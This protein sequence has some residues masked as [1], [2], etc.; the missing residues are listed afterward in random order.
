MSFV[1]LHVHSQ[2]SLLDG[3]SK[4]DKL[5]TRAQEMGM[6]AV[7]LTDHG[8]MFGT[9]D[10]FTAARKTG[11][12]P[13]IGLEAYMAARRMYDRDAK[14]DKRSSH[15]LLLAKNQIGYQNLLK[16]ASASQI[17]GFYYNPRIDHEFLAEHAEGL[18][19]SSGCM[20]AE[21]PRAIIDNNMDEVHKKLDWYYQVFGPENY[22]LELQSH[23]IQE[24]SK[25]NKTLLEVGKKYGSNFIATNDVHYVDQGDAY[26]Q[27]ILLAIQTG[28]LL[29]ETNRFRMSDDSYYLR[30]PQ[31]MMSLFA[32]IPGAIKNTVEIAERCNV[33]LTI[34]GYHLP[35]FEVPAGFTTQEY[36]LKVCDDGLKK[37]Y[38][39]HSEDKEVR[40]RL[41]Y[42]LGIIHE[43]G[44]DAYFL[45]VWDLCRHAREKGIWYNARGS[46]AGSM[47]AYV[48][49]ITLVEPLE[50]KLIFERFLN[51][52]RI[53]MPDI[54]L[55]FQ[56]DRRVEM[57]EYCA[58][59][60]GHDK[61][62]QI[63]TFGTLGARAAIRD[64]GRV[65]DIP[66]NEVDRV[67][68]SIPNIPSTSVSIK[69]ALEQSQEL[70][71]IYEEAD[72][73]AQLIDN[74]S[75]ME[76]SVRNA[77]THAA[78]VVITDEPVVNYLPLHRP[79]SGSEDSP[80]KTVTQYEMSVLDDLGLLK[81]DF[82]GLSTLTVMQKACD[83][84]EKRHGIKYDLSNIPLDD[85]E[86]Y[87]LLGKGNT[88][89]VFQLEGTGMTRHL[90]NM[91][92]HNLKNIIAMVALFRPG[93]MQFIPDYI[94]RMHGQD[95]PKYLH[96]KLE[97]I[98]SETYGIPIY[99]EQI[100]TAAMELAG[101]SASDADD[102]R[103]AISKKKIDKI[104]KHRER[105]IAGSVKNNVPK[106]TATE[107]FTEWE[108]FARYGFNKSHA[109]DYGVIAVQTAFLK[110]HYT[111]EY[112]TALLSVWKNV[113]DK[114][115]LYI[116]ECKS[117]G[118]EVLPPDIN[119]C[120]F[121]FTIED[122]EGKPPA[123][124]FG[125]GA[126][127]NVGQN[128]V[129]VIQDAANDGPFKD[130]N[131]FVR[132]VDL[133][134]VGKRPL[135]CLI[136]VGALDPLGKRTTLLD[137]LERICAISASH[138][139]ATTNGQMSIFGH[140]EGVQDEIYLPPVK[141]LDKRQ[142]LDWER[143]LLGVYVSDHPL[144]P[145]LPSIKKVIT[146]KSMELGEAES[147]QKVVV[148]G[149]ITN[150]RTTQ[151]KKGDQMGFCTLEDINGIMDLVIFP[152]PWDK[153]RGLIRKDTVVS[154]K[155]RVDTQR[156]GEPKILVSEIKELK[157]ASNEELQNIS[158]I[159]EENSDSD[160][161]FNDNDLN[162]V[163]YYHEDSEYVSFDSQADPHPDGKLIGYIFWPT[164]F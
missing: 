75:N 44:F 118:I 134:L 120:S 95:E 148:A 10:F 69:A 90:M 87:D 151:T 39:S 146:H 3:F 81:V 161:G 92:P 88:A 62:A 52:G 119:N 70:R 68:K 116:A 35:L 18:I 127:K 164:Q 13:I 57:L 99:Q 41:Q 80:I 19:C 93:P 43:M 82:L 71:D 105:F 56:D 20:A 55:D 128:P 97:P 83:L 149:M 60:Y 91:Q 96:P 163:Q 50:H 1:H 162:D 101:Y 156:E 77:G 108:N 12:K 110:T 141:E 138:F 7:A 34:E 22:Y 53:S 30:S 4:I 117:L 155:G 150:I 47:V 14:L 85:K 26:Y 9:I 136:K 145:Y 2:Y 61:V 36:L 115:S 16:I 135:E 100:M 29:S 8:T 104:K 139:K 45:I 121:D 129:Q 131:D 59:K 5:V 106:E 74:A 66:L 113:M 142:Y 124:R 133:R 63:I 125:L 154:V 42:E 86:T 64:V 84:I 132:R 31:E 27:D 46:A 65:L 103:K 76:G 144:S 78:G 15:I 152:K 17:E 67:A 49:D 160:N 6:P 23:N 48:L 40:E 89:G 28:S 159:D 112:M 25:I 79:T 94:L 107:I 38:G 98:F 58:N 153:Y 33:D 111:I 102:L 147:N 11:I 122:I 21:I 126:I 32:D 54:D 143:E 72:Y 157:P 140:S 24:L 158:Q 109:A 114:I 137:S 123:I 51:P 73:L 37:R 130:L